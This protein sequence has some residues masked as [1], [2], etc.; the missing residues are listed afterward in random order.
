LRRTIVRL[1]D[2]SASQRHRGMPTVNA[3]WPECM[4]LVQAL[5]QT[6]Q[7]PSDCT[8]SQPPREMHSPPRHWRDWAL[9]AHAANMTREDNVRSLIIL[10]F[11]STLT[12]HLLLFSISWRVAVAA[13]AV[14]VS[15]LFFTFNSII[16]P[17]SVSC[18]AC[19]H[20][21]GFSPVTLK[22][23]RQSLRPLVSHKHASPNHR[24][25]LFEMSQEA[26]LHPPRQ[27]IVNTRRASLLLAQL[28]APS[29][30]RVA[31]SPAC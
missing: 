25:F 30:W 29:D 15:C 31:A 10:D 24:R 21:V 12:L 19:M 23:T 2:C 4:R 18:L 3:A 6:Q 28:D 9:D 1:C 22:L 13:V 11:G 7:R 8:A 5:L 26:K 20:T 14:A 27:H 16:H 17:P